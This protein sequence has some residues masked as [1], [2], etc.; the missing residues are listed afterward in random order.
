MLRR[1]FWILNLALIGVAIFIGVDIVSAILE[2]SSGATSPVSM[3]AMARETPVP[4]V[5]PYDYYSIIVER[6]LFYP[7]GEAGI[8]EIESLLEVLPQTPLRLKLKGTVVGKGL[9]SFCIIQDLTAR[10]EEIY[11]IGDIIEPPHPD[12]IGAKIV[13]IQR[14]RVI[15]SRYGI[16]ETLIAYEDKTL[17]ARPSALPAVQ[18]SANRWQVSK[19]DLASM[20]RDPGK[21]LRDVMVNPYFEG[22]RMAGFRVSQIEKGSLVDRLGVQDG[23]IIKQVDGQPMNS[24][25]KAIQVYKGARNKRVISVDVERDGQM[26]T[27]TYEI[28]E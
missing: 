16:K 7:A 9:T 5:R 12:E 26:T 15:L 28:G 27:L 14:G 20:I 10:T 25:E 19:S 24:I 13:E 4:E 6:N 1:Y 2:S 8:G 3:E 17:S 18:S 11:R 21:I 22:G 23:D